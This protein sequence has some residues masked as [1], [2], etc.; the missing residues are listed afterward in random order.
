VLASLYDVF[1]SYA[2][3]PQRSHSSHTTI[4]DDE[5][6]KLRGRAL[7][8]LSGRDLSNYSMKAL[9][10]WGDETE[11]RHYLP[12][13]SSCSL[14]NQAGRM[15]RRCWESW[16]QRA[17]E[18][19]QKKNRFDRAVREGGVGRFAGREDSSFDGKPGTGCIEC[20]DSGRPLV[21]LWN[22][23]PGTSLCFNSPT[24]SR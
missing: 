10:T 24:S 14:P 4:N 20:W 19:G 22:N 9:T 23:I 13:L 17:G 7:R 21:E 3:P 16:R 5:A 6:D 15:F 18:N 1:A 12:R 8:T 2:P 11:F